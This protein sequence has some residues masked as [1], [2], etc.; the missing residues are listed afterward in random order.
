MDESALE[1]TLR[2]AMGGGY[3]SP[4]EETEEEDEQLE[5]YARQQTLLRRMQACNRDQALLTAELNRLVGTLIMSTR[6]KHGKGRR[7]NGVPSGQTSGTKQIPRNVLSLENQGTALVGDHMATHSLASEFRYILG[8]LKQKC[9]QRKTL[10]LRDLLQGVGGHGGSCAANRY[11]RGPLRGAAKFSKWVKEQ[12]SSSELGRNWVVLSDEPVIEISGYTIKNSLT[13]GRPFDVNLCTGITRV[14]RQMEVDGVPGAAPRHFTPVRWASLAM[15]GATTEAVET[16]N[17]P[18]TVARLDDTTLVMCMVQ[19][20]ATWACYAIDFAIRAITLM[21]PLISSP[22]DTSMVQ[23]H[24]F[25]APRIL[26]QA[27]YCMQKHTGNSSIGNGF[28]EKILLTGA[29]GEPQCNGEGSSICALNYARWFNGTTVCNPI[30]KLT[31]SIST[32][33]EGASGNADTIQY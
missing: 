17:P 29:D 22:N 15:S 27:I 6:R 11:V 21:D 9:P 2:P 32:V 5:E 28:W 3:I 23:M 1:L 14:F 16:F 20:G 33:K 8:G 10:N 18:H 25:N 26:S 24:S 12:D 19:I 31:A 30:G 7:G 13:R 4:H